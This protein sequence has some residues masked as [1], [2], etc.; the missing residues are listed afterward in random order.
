MST[1]DE[2]RYEAKRRYPKRTFAGVESHMQ[3]AFIKGAEWQASRKVDITAE[4]VEQVTAEVYKRLDF[5]S[6]EAGFTPT[7]ENVV[8]A[9]LTVAL[10]GGEHE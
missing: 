5:E 9:A 6:G 7:V 8:R 1:T 10:G 3:N 4:M 2:A